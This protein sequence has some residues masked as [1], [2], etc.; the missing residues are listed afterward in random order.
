[1]FLGVK[2]YDNKIWWHRALLDYHQHKNSDPLFNTLTHLVWRSAKVDVINQIQIP[3]QTEYATWLHLSA[4]ERHYYQREFDHQSKRKDDLMKTFPDK[5]VKIS[6]LSKH[7]L[8][9]FLYPL[10]QLRQA[11]IHPGV[12]TNGYINFEKKCISMDQV[13]AKLIESN[14]L[15]CEDAHRKLICALNGLAGVYIL[16]KEFNEA[17]TF[18]Q[19]VLSLWKGADLKTDSLQVCIL[20]FFLIFLTCIKYIP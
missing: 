14:T 16:K 18:Y 5:S 17:V 12:V 15:E 6:D 9:S 10:L 13:M 19:E 7:A 3:K 2:P 1:M 8:N 20:L 4:I 11:S